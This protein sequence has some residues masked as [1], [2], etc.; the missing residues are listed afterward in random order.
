MYVFFVDMFSDF[1][2]LVIYIIFFAMILTFYGLPLNI[3]RDVYM[4]GRSFF[5]KIR[6]LIRYR[7]ATKNMDD[8]YPT[9][10][11]AD[12]EAMSDGTCI[13][14][15]EEME[16]AG[17]SE[18]PPTTHSNGLNQTPKKL[19]CGH[20]FHFHCLRAWLERQQSCPTCRR[21][22]F[23]EGQGVAQR[24]Q[25]AAAH[26]PQPQQQQQPQAAP[27]PTPA[28]SAGPQPPAGAPTPAIPSTGTSAAIPS[29]GS[30]AA[31]ASG[32]S[33]AAVSTNTP[34]SVDGLQAFLRSQGLDRAYQNT[35]SQSTNP[36]K[37]KVNSPRA[38]L[39]D[40]NAFR[41]AFARPDRV[42]TV[43]GGE[44]SWLDSSAA[45]Q[46][47]TS[48]PL[49]DSS[50]RPQ[51]ENETEDEVEQMDPRTAARMAA[52]K[53]FG[54]SSS[55]E[56]SGS[57]KAESDDETPRVTITPLEAPPQASRSIQ[58]LLDVVSNEQQALTEDELQ[59]ISRLTRDGIEE[60]LR[61]L[62]RIDRQIWNSVQELTQCLSVLPEEHVEKPT[63]GADA[64]GKQ[65]AEG[66]NSIV[67]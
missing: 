43:N 19:P 17:S 47:S 44:L 20:I 18:V 62:H 2:K 65:P 24:P 52:L 15:R 31:D 61:V 6:D 40:P 16:I 63:E 33:S 45:A 59:S 53:R 66:I 13:I 56:A 51:D 12:M 28:P 26:P 4:T 29:R 9:A 27:A 67:A 34:R 41:S 3:V 37:Q 57:R 58:D 22:V 21:T 5:G 55:Q 1:F 14:C 49:A 30:I 64:K 50:S 42:P 39:Q 60:R 32:S 54:Q 7:A 38:T 11:A 36:R 25:P 23:Q 8:R 46:A 35:S 48:E 10:T